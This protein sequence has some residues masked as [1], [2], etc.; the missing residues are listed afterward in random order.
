MQLEQ[1]ALLMFTL[2]P[3]AEV[4]ALALVVVLLLLRA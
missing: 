1:P 2:T 4:S 3:E